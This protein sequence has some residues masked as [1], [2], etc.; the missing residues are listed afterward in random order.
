MADPRLLCAKVSFSV[1]A[2]LFVVL[3]TIYSIYVYCIDEDFWW[4]AHENF[5]EE[6]D[7]RYPSISICITDEGPEGFVKLFNNISQSENGDENVKENSTKI[8]YKNFLQGSCQNGDKTCIWDESLSEVDY[9]Q[10]TVPIEDYVLGFS[11][12]LNNK[13]K[14]WSF[15]SYNSNSSKLS[16]MLPKPIN[17]YTSKREANQKCLTSDIP[18]MQNRQIN[19]FGILIN[20]SLF[21]ENGVR[22]ERGGFSVKLHYPKQILVAKVTK[23]RWSKP[24]LQD[25]CST[26]TANCLDSYTM[27]FNIA[28]VKAISRRSKKK[29]KCIKDWENYDTSVYSMLADILECDPKHWNITKSF[30]KCKRQKDMKKAFEYSDFYNMPEN[31]PPPC[32]SVK[33]IIFQQDD[34]NGLF[35][36][37]TL[38]YPQIDDHL[39]ETSGPIEN[40]TVIELLLVFQVPFL[41]KSSFSI[42]R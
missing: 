36:F 4:N 27:H 9:D 1:L 21:G 7:G 35:S 28:N 6:N 12:F 39:K 37:S 40:E 41:Y 19:S 38:K 13:S 2:I 14:Y 8:T 26:D 15:K 31:I 3:F 30:V 33:N 20:R 11:L 5:H 24:P 42:V 17:V 16:S 25:E 29:Q 10:V 32:K 34:I 23:S 18:L 22:P